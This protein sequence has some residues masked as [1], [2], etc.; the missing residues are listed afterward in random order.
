MGR[1][2]VKGVEKKRRLVGNRFSMENE[3]NPVLSLKLGNVLSEQD[4][5]TEPSQKVE[6]EQKPVFVDLAD[7]PEVERLREEEKIVKEQYR[8]DQIQETLK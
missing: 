3:D 5:P 4:L 6:T 1:S 8:I 7:D 2:L